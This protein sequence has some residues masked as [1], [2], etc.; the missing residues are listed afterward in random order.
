MTPAG[1]W[2]GRRRHRP[3]ELVARWREA[4]TSDGQP[5][6]DWEHPANEALAEAI[7]DRRDISAALERHIQARYDA[8][9]TLSECATDLRALFERLPRRRAPRLSL[10]DVA[11]MMGAV[12][13]DGEPD[14]FGFSLSGLPDRTYLATRM[15]ETYRPAHQDLRWVLGVVRTEAAVGGWAGAS[16]QLRVTA[17]VE[18]AF[19]SAHSLAAIG[20]DCYVALQPDRADLAWSCVEVIETLAGEGITTRSWIEPLPPEPSQV[21]AVIEAVSSRSGRPLSAA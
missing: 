20:P 14:G 5:M 1:S 6:T 21:P 17:V 2:I 8:G 12:F 19:R 16:Q 4:A 15:R 10:F 9:F 18:R 13:I 3:D 7:V 11:A